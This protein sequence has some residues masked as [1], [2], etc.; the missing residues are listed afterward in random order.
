[1]SSIKG[2]KK[3][4]T[5]D[6]V[7]KIGMLELRVIAIN[8][9]IEE[10][11]EILGIELKEDSKAAIYLGESRDGNQ[12]TRTDFWMEAVEG[13]QK[14]KVSFFLEDADRMN[15]DE[16]KTQF[17]T[18]VGVTSWAEDEDG[19]ASWFTTREVRV[20]KRGEEDLYNFLRT[21]LGGLD[22]RDPDTEL[23]L[24]WKKLMKGNVDDL[25]ELI[26]GDYAVEFVG[27]AT[28]AIKGEGDD[29]KEYQG[30]YNKAFLPSYT[31]RYFNL[32]DYSN[33]EI[34]AKILGKTRKD[35]KFHERFIA[36]VSGEYGCKDVYSLKP[37]SDFIAE[38]HI[39]ASDDAMGGDGAHDDESGY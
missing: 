36:D 14:Y 3:E 11:Q 9:T 25:K 27:M 33:P 15:K 29:I 1:M 16:T 6:F 32:V 38:E 28:V 30:I 4:V 39:S 5:E 17:I 35:R 22:Y 10:Y 13:E 7:K 2:K 24:D 8:P 26:D 37:L 34:L 19:L 21:W 18:N 31:F 23:Q 20:A 12:Y